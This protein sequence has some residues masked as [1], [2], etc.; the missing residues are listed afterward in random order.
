MLGPLVVV[1]II[2]IIAMM[3]AMVRRVTRIIAWLACM[4]ASSSIV[5]LTIVIAL[6][7]RTWQFQSIRILILVALLVRLIGD[8]GIDNK[9]IKISLLSSRT[10]ES[11]IFVYQF[12]RGFS[13]TD[14]RMLS[15]FISST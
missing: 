3:V 14:W 5:I 4:T 15:F 11:V 12:H 8:C 2:S 10:K 6:V 7:A 13:I 9:P 1:G